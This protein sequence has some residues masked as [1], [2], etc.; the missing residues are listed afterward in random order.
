MYLDYA[1][2]RIKYGCALNHYI[3][4][5][6]YKYSNFE[7]R[8]TF[9]Y[10]HWNNVVNNYNDKDSTEY[11]KNKITLFRIPYTQINNIEKILSEIL[12]E[13]RSTTIEKFLITE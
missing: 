7:R 11:L 10:K 2:S 4:G 3:V 9:T 6:F 8:K 5:N 12:E 13:K 1:M